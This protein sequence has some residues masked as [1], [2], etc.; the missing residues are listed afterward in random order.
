MSQQPPIDH[1]NP[2]AQSYFASAPGFVPVV[3]PRASIAKPPY[4]PNYPDAVSS[5]TSSPPHSPAPPGY[6]Q[7]TPS[8]PPQVQQQFGNVAPGVYPQQQGYGQQ[9]PQYGYDQQQQQPQQGYVYGQQQVS[10]QSPPQQQG[11]VFAAELSAQRG[12][13]ELRELA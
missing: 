9:Q 2:G 7:G 11:G 13:G 6:Q 8:P 1:N 12:D 3:D 10:P 5:T 4:G